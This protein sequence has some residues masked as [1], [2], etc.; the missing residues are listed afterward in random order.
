MPFTLIT[1]DVT[2]SG[3]AF[4][5]TAPDSTYILLPGVNIIGTGATLF[6]EEQFH[7]NTQLILGGNMATVAAFCVSLSGSGDRVTITETGFLTATW[8][9][10][11]FPIVSLS[12]DDC[13]V[14]NAGQIVSTRGSGISINGTGAVGSNSGRIEVGSVGVQLG[15]S[16][17]FVN[18]GEIIVASTGIAGGISIGGASG[19]VENSG[20]ISV[21]GPSSA[22]GVRF[23]LAGGHLMNSGTITS[24]S[25]SGVEA[26]EAVE[27]DNSGTISGGANSLSLSSGADT[28][29][30]RGLLAGNVALGGGADRFDGRHGQ[31]TGEVLGG[32]GDDVYLMLGNDFDLV[33]LAGEGNDTVLSWADHAMEEGVETLLLKGTAERGMGTSQAD[34]I[35]GNGMDNLLDGA[36]GGDSLQGFEGADTLRGAQGDDSLAGGDGTDLLSG[37]LGNDLLLGEAG[38]DLLEGG[39]GGDQLTGGEE[40]DTLWG[41]A[42]NDTLTGG[43]EDDLLSGGRG[44]DSL[45]G[46][47]GSDIF[48]LTRLTDSGTVFATRDV[49]AD[50]TTGEDVID[51][52]ALDARVGGADD[53]FVFI[54]SAAFSSVAGQLRFR[55]AGANVFVDGD[56]NGDGVADLSIAVNA[57]TSLVATDF[58]L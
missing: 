3:F 29:V 22:Y 6:Y 43:T 42:G 54:G 15:A 53:A 55:V 1:T 20:T 19:S 30:N 18:S 33:E 37:G 36:A 12:G 40:D 44:R 48:A 8:F 5:V 41:G 16:S 32:T 35:L 17:S 38:R 56:V 2:S 50:F 39:Q 11:G 28:V 31:V 23:A 24:A 45:T 25:G 47:T 9:F 10:D 49:I 21:A 13:V 46:G 34:T 4:T 51:L 14:S 26:F 7:G 27:I 58:L 52:S 57:V